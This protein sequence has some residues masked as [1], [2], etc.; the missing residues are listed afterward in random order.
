MLHVHSWG[1]PAA[2]PV[3]CLHGIT[4]HGRR[5]RRL[6]E[7]HLGDRFHVLA[8]DLLGHGLSEWEPPWGIRSQVDAVLAVLDRYGI[9][10]ARW[11]GHSFGGRLV[12]ELTARE[13]ARVD[14][15][16]L[17]DPAIWVPPPVALE[18]AEDER[19]ERSFSSHDEAFTRRLAKGELLDE[20][21][22]YVRDDFLDHLVEHEDG[23]LRPRYVQSAVVTAFSEMAMPPPEFAELAVPTLIVRGSLSNVT[24]DPL[25][26]LYRD[27]IGDLLSLVDVPGYHSPLW[28]AFDVTA[29]EI[30]RFFL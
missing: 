11:I 18:R 10:S 16:V 6:A 21:H 3:V 20:A 23:R 7:E 15:V 17:L 27:G 9:G 19:V 4:G 25:V 5:F 22:P 26:E 28:D 30:D 12:M 24:P 14:R 8:P 29:A 13:R 2:P 1:D